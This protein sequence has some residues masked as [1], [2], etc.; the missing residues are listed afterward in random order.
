MRLSPM[1]SRRGGLT[2]LLASPSRRMFGC[3]SVASQSA[4]A[5]AA[6]TGRPLI[7]VNHMVRS[8]YLPC[9]RLSEPSLTVDLSP[10]P[11]KDTPSLRS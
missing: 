8:V 1:R 9:G 10:S 11:S 6:A 7:G 3:L 2:P 5:L 4:A